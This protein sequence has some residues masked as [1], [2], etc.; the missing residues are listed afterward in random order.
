MSGTDPERRRVAYVYMTLPVGGAE[1]HLV[2]ILS[3]LDRA[4]FDPAVVCLGPPGALGD[5]LAASGEAVTAFGMPTK[6]AWFPGRLARVAAFLRRGRFDIV[7]THMSHAN[8]YGRLAAVWAGVPH[9][10]AT[11]HTVE[12]GPRRKH[13]LLNRWL[14]RRTDATVAVTEEARQ[15]LIAGARLPPDRVVT[16][17]NGV[18]IDRLRAGPGRAEVRAALGLTE[19]P[20]VVCCVARLD[21]AKRHGDLL[22]AF[23]AA[24]RD[25]PG[26]H[27]LLAG[28]G[29]A[30]AD[31]RAAVDALGLA[32]AVSV[33]GERSDVPELLRA[34]DVFALASERE[35]MPLAVAEAMA[36]GCAVVATGVGG[37]PAMVGADAGITVPPGDVPAL[38]AAL[39][40]CLSDP[41]LRRRLGAA[42]RAHAEAEFSAR[43][44]VRRL[45]ALYD[46]IAPRR[47]IGA[48]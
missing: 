20:P 35:G 16:I 19:T 29:K 11:V 22:R 17:R 9:R 45:E 2:H 31:I 47:A 39:R 12:A 46:R 41:A 1:Y 13:R 21:P 23:E 3:F 26:A 32:A 7:H 38:A 28:G 10:V 42:G 6:R 44:M 34:S 15:A 18:D 25:V 37:V 40:A 4:R 24:R 36:C 14:D 27:L 30:E 43:T 8:T 33:L 5:R 48:V